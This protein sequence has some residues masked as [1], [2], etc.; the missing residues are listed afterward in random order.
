MMEE[1]PQ[2]SLED[3]DQYVPLHTVFL[4]LWLSFPDPSKFFLFCL[5]KVR[6]I[7]RSYQAMS[8]STTSKD[9]HGFVHSMV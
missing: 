8:I 1:P 6:Y 3:S 9:I 4:T 2:S 7:L 5:N